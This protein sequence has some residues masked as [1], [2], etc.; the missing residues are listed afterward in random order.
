M[1]KQAI[2]HLFAIQARAGAI[3]TRDVGDQLR[4]DAPDRRQFRNDGQ[5]AQRSGRQGQGS[6]RQ[7]GLVR[8]GLGQRLHARRTVGAARLR[9]QRHA[10]EQVEQLPA[11]ATGQFLL[12]FRRIAPGRNVFR[13][14]HDRI[15]VPCRRGTARTCNL[16]A[17]GAKTM[18]GKDSRP[19]LNL[20]WL[21]AGQQAGDEIRQFCVWG[22]QQGH[23]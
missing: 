6:G 11:D 8:G 22:A 7:R 5:P 20:L 16:D 10:A 9:G 12:G 14:V 15:V 21:S 1:P 3:G 23:C 4:L 13:F 19:G 18:A 2:H 17:I